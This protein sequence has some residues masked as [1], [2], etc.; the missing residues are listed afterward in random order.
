MLLEPL[1]PKAS[2]DPLESLVS[3]VRRGLLVLAVP[4]A[5]LAKLVRMV[6]PGSLDGLEREEWLDHRV[7]VASLGLL[8]SLASRVSGDTMVW[9]D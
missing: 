5:P 9:M 2:K 4:L 1:A 8:D 6:I 3:L 7:L